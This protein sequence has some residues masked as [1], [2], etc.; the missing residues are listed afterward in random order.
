MASK[1]SFY[2]KRCALLDRLGKHD[3]NEPFD[4]VD[5]AEDLVIEDCTFRFGNFKHFILRLEEEG[6]IVLCFTTY[7]VKIQRIKRTKFVLRSLQRGDCK[8]SLTVEG[9]RT[10]G[11]TTDI[12]IVGDTLASSRCLS[13]CLTNMI[14]R[15]PPY[16]TIR[17]PLNSTRDMFY[18]STVMTNKQQLNQATFTD[19]YLGDLGGVGTIFDYPP[20]ADSM[21]P[22]PSY[23]STSFIQMK[24]DH[25]MINLI[26]HYGHNLD[27]LP[28]SW[29]VILAAWLVSQARMKTSYEW[30]HNRRPY[31]HST[32]SKWSGFF[33]P[34]RATFGEGWLTDM[35]FREG[36]RAPLLP[37]GL[38]PGKKPIVGKAW[39]N[40]LGNQTKRRKS[41]QKRTDGLWLS[42]L[43]KQYQ[44]HICDFS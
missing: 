23:A 2:S 32:P 13:D 4:L 17:V 5:L 22:A 19:I 31:F 30:K 37:V 1:I 7:K 40:S 42:K 21:L 16:S 8:V 36:Y 41:Q 14:R 20:I 33:Q 27:S 9:R 26:K 18:V 11:M 12:D 35:S 28:I 10:V 6:L 24:W 38:I 15:V 3:W 25:L 39:D 43:T 44:W 29:Q 34:D